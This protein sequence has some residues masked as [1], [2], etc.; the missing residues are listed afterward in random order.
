MSDPRH[1]KWGEPQTLP[2]DSDALHTTPRLTWRELF[3]TLHA[4]THSY[5]TFSSEKIRARFTLLGISLIVLAGVGGQALINQWQ[6]WFFNALEN[7]DIIA[8]FKM[9]GLFSVLAL[10]LILCFV[11]K[12]FFEAIL[13]IRWRRWLTQEYVHKWL[14][15]KNYYYLQNIGF[16]ADNPDQ[17][18]AEDIQTFVRETSNL[19][20]GFFEVILMFTVFSFVLWNL[21]GPLSWTWGAHMYSIPGYMFWSA[22]LLVG[23]GTWLVSRI[24]LPFIQL[25]YNQERYQANFRFSMMRVREHAESIA[26]WGGETQENATVGD[27]FSFVFQNFWR[28]IYRS[29]IFSTFLSG[30]NQIAIIFPYLVA[31]P[32]Y[33]RGIITLG[34][35]MQVADAFM[36]VHTSSSYII[37]SY[38]T[39]ADWRA[40]VERLS[41]F[42]TAVKLV[43]KEVAASQFKRTNGPSDAISLENVE[44]HL[45][46]GAH[47][48]GP[49]TLSF[50]KGPWILLEGPSGAG[51]STLLRT[52]AGLW[53]YGHGTI[54]APLSDMLFL[55]QKP[56]M[57][58]GTLKD[59]LIYPAHNQDVPDDIAAPL[60]ERVGLAHLIPDLHTR[61]NWSQRLS[62]GEQQRLG[63]ARLMH[64]KPVWAFLDEAMSS[65][66]TDAEA[67]LYHLIRQD[68]PE[69][70][71]FSIV[72]R[73]QGRRF[74][75]A[76]YRI[77]NNTLIQ[78]VSEK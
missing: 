53:L 47:L 51:K 73:G 10:F 46:N 77:K 41:G 16:Y 44:I 23:A 4:L 36:H 8:F 61:D 65:L 18:I 45:P 49:L 11:F 2:T 64:Q 32:Q 68:A 60:L 34:V 9:M 6:A 62:G 56:Y 71:L 72:H 50:R 28:I 33:F 3:H 12:N 75:D 74:H 20:F 54:E 21:S 7:K 70:T 13:L 27:Q 55:S 57:P 19:F 63:I 35:L 38:T 76:F 78:E 37:N 42:L 29:R 59:A 17:R 40:V 39:I 66:D 31:S 67:A 24:G 14:N 69:T 26:F 5:F 52:L 58:L 43:E 22:L 30:Y 15:H 1:A 48:L 25:Y